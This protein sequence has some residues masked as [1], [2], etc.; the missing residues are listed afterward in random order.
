M[1]DDILVASAEDLK[2]QLEA[3]QPADGAAVAPK[4][5]EKTDAQAE[6][7]PAPEPGTEKDDKSE[8]KKNGG[9]QK[10]IDK[11]TARNY[12]LEKELQEA[13]VKKDPPAAAPEP[14]G[15]P[16]LETYKTREEWEEAVMDWKIEQRVAKEREESVQAEENARTAEI[17]QAHN[18]RI[19]EARGKYDDFEE[20]VKSAKVDFSRDA[21]LA[22]FELENGPDVMYHL[23]THQDELKELA[24]MSPIRQIAK[25][26]VI[27]QSLSGSGSPS[28]VKPATKV[29]PPIEPVG[30]SGATSTVDPDS[31]STDE[32]VRMRNK[33][34]RDR[35]KR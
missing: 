30:A 12:E 14:P 1:P 3:A 19:S 24:K 23:A 16:Q 5:D 15:K 6:I 18:Q 17:F 26:G 9:W 31:L 33:E 11:L 32:Y 27:S 22:I 21:G 20:V 13:R 28:A 2:G 4:Q 35:R 29:P 34:E 7:A 8:P 25:L 10:R